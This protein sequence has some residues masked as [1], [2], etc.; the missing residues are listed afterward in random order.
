MILLA[1]PYR[2]LP[3]DSG[4]DAPPPASAPRWTLTRTPRLATMGPK[5]PLHPR[6][7]LLSRGVQPGE[8][9]QPHWD[10]ARSVGSAVPGVHIRLVNTGAGA[11]RGKIS[12]GLDTFKSFCIVSSTTCLNRPLDSPP[13]CLIM[14]VDS[15]RGPTR[16]VVLVFAPLAA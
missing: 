9:E 11:A 5:N 16:S 14:K 6:A 7:G 4:L 1:G 8:Q 10:R 15:E 3:C 12:A 13:P 2:N